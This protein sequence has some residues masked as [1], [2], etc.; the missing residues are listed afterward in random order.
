MPTLTRDITDSTDKPTYSVVPNTPP[1]AAK[2]PDV[3]TLIVNT[4]ARRGQEWFEK[5]QICLRESG[6]RIDDAHA[7]EDPA[8]LPD[9]V[10]AAVKRGAK[11]V[12]V[13]GG[14]GT[15][16]TVANLLAQ[17]DVTL[18]VLPLGTVN[19]LARNLG[20][21]CDVEAACR[22]IAE[23]C[24]ASID[25]GQAND[26]VFLLTASVGFSA[27]SQT[28]L[29]PALKRMLGPFGY[30]A[31]SLVAL[32]RLRELEVCIRAEGRTERYRVL[33]AG[34]I[35]GHEWMGGK[36]QIPGMNLEVGCLAFYALPPQPKRMFLRTVRDLM[37]GRFFQTP[38]LKSFAATEVSIETPIPQP[39]VLDGDLCGQT[40]VR[41]RVLPEALRVFVPSA[42]PDV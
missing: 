23:G 5:A 9:A 18:G 10:R 3:A 29:K 42:F 30:L 11:R 15:F 21:Q 31:A 39:L 36:C 25:V 7:L 2:T 35:K 37:H 22:V 38:G 8:G 19:D 32:R 13:G 14:D 41:L 27:Q 12:I 40:P 20:I 28:A 17:T 16:R 4:R 34:V 33:Q 6:V 1:D 26:E 24:V